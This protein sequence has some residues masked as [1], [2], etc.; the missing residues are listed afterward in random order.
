MQGPTFL[1]EF[2][3]TQNNGNHVHSIWRDFTGDFGRDLLRDHLQDGDALA[4]AGSRSRRS[5]FRRRR[6]G[7]DNTNDARP[8]G[9]AA[10]CRSFAAR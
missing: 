3:N 10:R 6:T 7:P 5:A 1:I 9:I 4:I 2:D 8:D